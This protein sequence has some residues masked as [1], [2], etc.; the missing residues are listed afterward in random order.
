[1]SRFGIGQSVRRVEDRRLLSGR[2]QYVDDLKI[3]GVCHGVVVLSSHAH[4]RLIRINVERAISAA[5]IVCVLTGDDA[6]RDSLGDLPPLFLPDLDP[7]HPPFQANRPV[8]VHDR[9]RCVG[10]R[11]AFVVAETLAQATDAAELIE[12]EY[13]AL[14]VIS[15]LEA[16][17]KSG[18]I[19][20]WN[21]CPYR[22]V[23]F[24]IGYG[25]RQKT[26]DAFK[27][28]KYRVALRLENQRLLA[29]SLEPRTAIG[30]FDPAD[31]SFTLYTSSQNPHG[32][33]S[34]A[35][36][37]VLRIPETKIRVIAPDVGGG[38]GLKSNAHIE[39]PL[40]LWASRRCGRP[41]KWT[42]TRSEGMLGD[43]QGRGQIA[44]GEMALDEQGKILAIRVR[45]LHDVGAYTSAVC[46]APIIFSMQYVPNV[47]D[48]QTV[49]LRTQGIFTNTT[50]VTAYR[51][52]GRPE[53]I[54]LVERLLDE[55]AAKI[56]ISPAEIR[57]KNFIPPSAMPYGTAT[58]ITYDSGAFKKVLER[59]LK[60]SDW[61]GFEKRRAAAKGSGKRLG[62]GM[63]YYI[64]TA[65]HDNERMGI[66]FDPGGTI[67]I[68]A[69]THSHGQ[70]HATTYAQMLTEWLG[71]SF[72]DIRLLQGDT[73]KV[74][75]GRGTYGARSSM[76]GG[77]ALK[78]AADEVIAKAKL[79]AAEMLEADAA[80]IEFLNGSFQVQ[81][82]DKTVSLIDVAKALYSPGGITDKFGV[83]L[84]GSGTF[85]T[86]PPNHPN[87]C[88]ICEVEVDPETGKTVIARYTVVDDAGRVINPLICEGQVHGGLAQGIGQALMEQ[89]VYEPT[90]G[91]NLS[92]SFMDYA[93]P[94][95]HDLPSFHTAFEEVLCK[96]NPLGVKG[97]GEAG[98]IG[99]PPAVIN[100]IIDALRDLGVTEIQMPATS[101]R[102]WKAISLAASKTQSKPRS[103]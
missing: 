64:E 5:G 85:G 90:S 14:P 100:A 68:V 56:G 11:V 22:N 48:V 8:L 3:P 78:G 53:A 66:H 59:C 75:F 41:V 97:I 6:K 54:Y 57:Q 15:D 69:G 36:R 24:E 10:D 86:N 88:H 71:V 99:A 32:V 62:R 93:M 87:G 44:D 50:P 45:A 49:D 81:G 103:S 46:A 67:T 42:A 72:N 89:V 98:S 43:Y 18:A 39:E 96:T 60:E 21:E 7:D 25:D 9:V 23:A 16:A 73:D 47:Y 30:I 102:V 80:D 2:G 94:R 31:S 13:E 55:A 19:P 84:E 37:Q 29:N 35:A 70:G 61:A 101:A 92:A 20:I 77:C 91:Q 95:A 38:F 52:T 83:G 4:A 76:N 82:T 74:S 79:M 58:G 28:A 26:D 34:L 65:G 63:S 12:I 1:M 40:V 51:G 33:R 27:S 17:V